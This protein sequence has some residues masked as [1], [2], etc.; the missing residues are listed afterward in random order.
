[1]SKYTRKRQK[2]PVPNWPRTDER[3]ILALRGMNDAV[4]FL[5]TILGIGNPDNP[6]AGWWDDDVHTPLVRWCEAQI[7][8]WLKARAKR[9]TGRRYIAI[10]VPRLCGK[11]VLIT[12]GLMLWM[13]VLDVNL[14][15]AIGNE[16]RPLAKT[17][18]GAIGDWASGRDK[19][20]LFPW[21]YGNWA[22]G[23][24][25]WTQEGIT[26]AA[27][28]I[29]RGEQSFGIFSLGSG[30]TGRH[31]DVLT[32]DDLVSY[33]GLE[34][35]ANLFE[36]AWST[37]S[38]ITPVV[39][40]DGIV[41]L[42]GTRYG[43]GDPHARAFATDGILSVSGMA[44]P[45]YVARPDGLW[46][47]YFLSGRDLDGRPAIPSIWPETEMKRWEKRDPIK[48]VFQV[49]CRPRASTLHV[50]TE[51][52]FTKSMADSPPR[53]MNVCIHFDAA[54]KHPERQSARHDTAITI[55]GHPDANG[56]IVWFLG[57]WNSPDWTARD[58]AMRVLACHRWCEANGWRVIMFTDEAET[59]GKW[60]VFEEF[61][62]DH[63]A[64]AGM[65]M[66][67]YSSSNRLAIGKSKDVRLTNAL[68]FFQSNKVRVWTNAPGLPDFR[69]Q[70]LGYPNLHK[71]DVIDSFA[72]AWHPDVYHA[73]FSLMLMPQDKER[74]G[75]IN[76]QAYQDYVIIGPQG[77]LPYDRPPII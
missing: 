50:V 18:V 19:F 45:E 12:K 7:I 6:L 5:K 32:A 35:D 76:D 40:K 20:S 64:T 68:A 62:R 11:T 37:L 61:L 25:A 10:V 41:W 52:Q 53:G 13:H 73:K 46:R 63:Y 1:M 17:F 69:Y 14:A 29:T 67:H 43:D 70:V 27:R 75:A 3:D 38:A 31:V 16:S 57:A 30:I 34:K 59:G 36:T 22:T 33:E 77:D 54:F 51:A 2:S 24:K 49:L 47:L 66:P 9:K 58:A 44:D 71:K 26:H 48:Y 72:D 42:I 21:L 60:G 23:A 15:T 28:Q 8:S 74:A 55:S 56:D 39:E 65:E 4:F